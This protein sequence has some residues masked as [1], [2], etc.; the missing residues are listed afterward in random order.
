MRC[1]AACLGPDRPFVVCDPRRRDGTES[2][3]SPG[4]YRTGTAAAQAAIGG[5]LCMRAKRLP[6]D[7]PALLARLREPSTDVQLIIC[8]EREDAPS[9]FFNPIDVPSLSA[10][11]QDL[12]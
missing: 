9:L 2:V 7:F 3:R 11:A 8:L 4:N 5:S 1:I 10:R 12:P 6:R